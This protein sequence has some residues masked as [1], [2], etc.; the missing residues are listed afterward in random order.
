MSLRTFLGA[1]RQSAVRHFRRE[2]A[3]RKRNRRVQPRRPFIESLGLAR[4]PLLAALQLRHPH[5]ESLEAR[6]LLSITANPDTYSTIN[7][8][9][10][11][12]AAP[13]V[14]GN[15]VDSNGYAMNAVLPSR[16]SAGGTL[17]PD[18]NGDG[19]FTYTPPAGYFGTDSFMYYATD[20]THTQSYAHVTINVSMGIISGTDSTKMPVDTLDVSRQILSDPYS[21]PIVS[22][23]PAG[24]S[25]GTTIS[26]E[27]ADG[28]P[29]T[30]HNLSLV[31]DSVAGHPDQVLEGDFQVDVN[32]GMPQTM[33]ATATFNGSPAGTSFISTAYLANEPSIHV[34]I[35]V[36]TSSLPTGRYPYSLALSA[37][38]NVTINGFANV[39]NNSASPFG[40]GWDMPGVYHVYQNNVQGV[41]AGVLLTPGDGTGWYFT[42]AGGNTFSSPAGP[43]AFDTLT[44]VTGGGWQLL[45]KYGTTFNF[46][47]SG[48]L[49]S[50]V[51]RTLETTSYAWTSGDLTAITGAFGR[52]VELAYASGLLSSIQDFA[53][54][55]WSFAHTGGDLTGI[56]LP[57]PG[58]GSPVWSYAYSGNY[59]SN[60]TDPSSNQTS[61]TLSSEHRVSSVSLPGG[62]N[63][64]AVSEQNYGYGSTS[65]SNPEAAVLTSSVVPSTTDANQNTSDYQSDP[66]GDP[67]SEVDPYGNVTGI[68]RDANGLPTQ[69]T[70]PPPASGDPSP[71]TNISYDTSGNETS[72]SGAQPTYRTWTYNTFGEWETFTD[73][74]GKEWVRTFDSHGNVLTET[75]PLSNQVSWTY[76]QYGRPLTM[77]VPAPN[78]GTGTVTTHYFYDSYERLVQITWPDNSTQVLGYQADDRQKSFTDENNHTTA[79]NFDAL[80]RVTSI[81]NAANGTVS[82]T[83][84]KD[85]NRLTT[86]D[87]MSNVTT[88]QYNAR[89]ELVQETLP[90][91]AVGQTAPVLAWT[92]D[93]NG[94]ELT[95]T[96][97]LGRVTSEAWDKLDRITSETLPPPASGKASPVITTAYD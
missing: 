14:L 8:T 62:A 50:R 89:N 7:T 31:Y 87:E 51:E 92:F 22:P 9:Q 36:D 28:A 32:G 40:M 61:F 85:N 39:V 84:D 42:S 44:S 74:T 58:G 75:D 56:T 2:N 69:I 70:L 5:F 71:V 16:T 88:D 1:M 45:D 73:S 20:Q 64:S 52:S 82:F 41:P 59:L 29:A 27:P 60:E 38:N 18:G 65:H 30:A 3:R 46:D 94:N 12:V 21:Q 76:D 19:G 13:G 81:V 68:Q 17:Q 35:Q 55:T 34:A 37:A 66:F 72:A 57:N 97:G 63:T 90:A 67:T 79:T 48:D 23:L 86:T 47:S 96:D 4:S 25:G 49:T 26:A 43:Y 33:T 95:F 91:P 93:A 11:V 10:L 80:G 77:T 24:G 78:N 83:W 15:D 54:S 6:D 53:G